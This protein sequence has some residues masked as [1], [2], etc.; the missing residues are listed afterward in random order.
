MNIPQ[1]FLHYTLLFDSIGNGSQLYL[2]CLPFLACI[3]GSYLYSDNHT[4]YTLR[5]KADF[6]SNSARKEL[7]LAL[8]GK[9][10]TLSAFIC[11][12]IPCN[13]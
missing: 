7:L 11:C 3:G 4:C 6:V 1:N 13:G 5:H 8:Y 12:N 9:H 10:N 2:L